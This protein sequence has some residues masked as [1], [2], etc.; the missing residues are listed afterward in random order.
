MHVGTQEVRY[1][2]DG[3]KI[4]GKRYIVPSQ[5]SPDTAIDT[6]YANDGKTVSELRYLVGT[7]SDYKPYGGEKSYKT[8][9][10]MEYDPKTGEFLDAVR[11]D[12]QAE[13]SPLI[14]LEMDW[15]TLNPDFSSSFL[16]SLKSVNK[17]VDVYEN[18]FPYLLT[19]PYSY[20]NK[21]FIR[22]FADD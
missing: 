15:Q 18:S 20:R 3:S 21:D 7:K 13:G 11:Y 22:N 12:K 19:H 16:K 14:D 4:I 17:E 9:F 10:K 2:A 6:C 1:S 8:L 5:Y